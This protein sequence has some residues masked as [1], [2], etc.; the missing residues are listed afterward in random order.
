MKGPNSCLSEFSLL[1]IRFHF[2]FWITTKSNYRFLYRDSLGSLCSLPKGTLSSINL[3]FRKLFVLQTI[4]PL[5]NSLSCLSYVLS[6][7]SLFSLQSLQSS[8]NT[9]FLK[10]SLGKQTGS[11]TFLYHITSEAM[12]ERACGNP[13]SKKPIEL[14]Y[15]RMQQK[16]TD[17]LRL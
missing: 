15:Y 1:I 5:T 6:Q 4:P 3:Y 12:H 8:I 11:L 9:A 14:R 16:M 10:L 13:N 7:A 17:A 2:L